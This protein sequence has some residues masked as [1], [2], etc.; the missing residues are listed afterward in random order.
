MRT[1]DWNFFKERMLAKATTVM[2]AAWGIGLQTGALSVT[3]GIRIWEGIV[4]PILEYGSE[5]WPAAHTDRWKEAEAIQKKMGKRILRVGPKTS[6]AVVYG[7][8]GWWTLRGR[9]MLLRLKY[10]WKLIHMGSKA[11]MVR[12]M[13]DCSR[14]KCEANEG[15][16]KKNR[17]SNWCTYTKQILT[18]LG[19]E[20]A[21]TSGEVGTRSEWDVRV[22]A[23]IQDK[24]QTMWREGMMQNKVLVTYAKFK[25]TLE[26][27]EYLE[28]NSDAFGRMGLTRLRSGNHCLSI[29]VDRWKSPKSKR[30]DRVC[31][32][33][34]AKNC[35]W[36]WVMEDE[37]HFMLECPSYETERT[38]WRKSR[39]DILGKKEVIA[40]EESTEMEM[41]RVMGPAPKDATKNERRK[42][43]A[44]NM[45]FVRLAMKKRKRN[46]EELREYLEI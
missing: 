29:N 8:L 36:N 43:N 46:L 6:D 19:L 41:E 33:C 27:E 1:G 15:K 9:R 2:N 3:G 13:Y 38:Q 26:R 30:E 20:D 28:G 34:L 45:L 35:S 10:W 5:I 12:R 17:V 24:E 11:R 25:K 32:Q 37:A 39:N 4:R 23:A 16:P 21:W 22:R 18:E 14:E 7:E 40:E 31:D 44:A 42:I